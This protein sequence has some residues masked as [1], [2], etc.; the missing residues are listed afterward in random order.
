M[1]SQ[2]ILEQEERR[3]RLRQDYNGMTLETLLI[4]LEREVIQFQILPV[5]EFLVCKLN[6]AGRTATPSYFLVRL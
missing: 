3:Q 6:R 2:N 1:V 5:L 4:M